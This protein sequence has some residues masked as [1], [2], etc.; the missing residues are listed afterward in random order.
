MKDKTITGNMFVRKVGEHTM[1]MAII[2]SDTIPNIKNE[3]MQTII[4]Q[5]LPG[6][7][8]RLQTTGEQRDI[9]KEVE[10]NSPNGIFQMP[11]WRT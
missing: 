7:V 5:E 11:I 9:S 6:G 1:L 4:G 10:G 8:I 2:K 3:S